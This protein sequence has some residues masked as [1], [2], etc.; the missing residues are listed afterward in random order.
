MKGLTTRQREVLEYIAGSI[1]ETGYPPTIREIG[2]ALAIR[3]T[4][5][6]NDHLKA[7]A[8]K[9]YIERD[10]SK[11]RAILLTGMAEDA[12]GLDGNPAP[13]VVSRDDSSRETVEV[14]VFGRIAAGVP[15]EASE[16][17]EDALHLDASLVGNGRGGVYALRVQGDSM[18]GDGIFD[19]DLIFV[20]P[21]VEARKGEMVA[22]RIE[23]GATVKRYYRDGDVVRL[24]PSNPEMEPIVVRADQARDAM[25]LGKVVGVYR[26]LA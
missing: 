26:S 9:G 1:S 11:S 12:L 22:V 7:L 25:I 23:D 4:N 18:I 15:I 5:G 6:V 13:G 21:E 17:T 20:R 16:A 10:T 14:P 24:E 2:L 8:R 3:S 19:G